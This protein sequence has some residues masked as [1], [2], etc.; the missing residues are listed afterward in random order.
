MVAALTAACGQS[1]PDTQA[2]LAG[3]QASNTHT[4]LSTT[5]TDALIGN[6]LGIAPLC[7]AYDYLVSTYILF[8]QLAQL[9]ASES[10]A[11]SQRAESAIKLVAKKAISIGL[12]QQQI[13]ALSTFYQFTP[14]NK[15]GTSAS[16]GATLTALRTFFTPLCQP[17]RPTGATTSQ[18]QQNAVSSGMTS[19]CIQ[20][21]SYL[22]SSADPT[23][24]VV[25]ASSPSCYG[26]GSTGVALR[27]SST[28]S[29]LIQR[30]TN[31]PCG[32]MPPWIIENLFG[33]KGV[34]SCYPGGYLTIG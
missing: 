30:F 19:K 32:Q 1:S 20:S 23:Y 16:A 10:Q 33:D 13:L 12:S 15:G 6:N 11:A 34:T 18:M 22:I 9:S 27:V 14:T 5:T 3:P 17:M 29:A 21:S 8:P 31:Y 7:Q 2:N 28:G 4:L 26:D 24:G 25:I